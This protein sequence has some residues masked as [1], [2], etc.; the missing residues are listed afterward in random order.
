MCISIYVIY[1]LCNWLRPRSGPLPLA[2][3]LQRP[4]RRS[5][6]GFCKPPPTPHPT[7]SVH[8]FWIWIGVIWTVFTAPGTWN[9]SVR[10]GG[11]GAASV[12]PTL[13]PP[14][15]ASILDWDWCGLYGIYGIWQVW[16]RVWTRVWLRHRR[17]VY[18]RH[19]IR[20]WIRVWMRFSVR[21][22]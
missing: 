22:P 4:S 19:W 8:L 20:L 21:S 17:R 1:V 13:H 9:F 10:R 2:V 5:R 3:R 14:F 12:S 6:G 7:H 15:G 16:L 11:L 18:I